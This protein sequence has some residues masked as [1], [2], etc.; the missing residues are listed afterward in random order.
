MAQPVTVAVAKPDDMS[1]NPSGDEENRV[2]CHTLT[3]AH[4]LSVTNPKLNI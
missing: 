1:A 3:L 2:L 4:S